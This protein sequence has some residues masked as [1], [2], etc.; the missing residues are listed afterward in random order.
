[1]DFRRPVD[2]LDN[3]GK[4]E[5]QL[6]GDLA[7]Q[8]TD[9]ANSEP[10]L[11][12]CILMSALNIYLYKY[13]KAP[14]IV[15]GSPALKKE[16]DAPNKN[17][18][19]AIISEIAEHCSFKELL[20]YIKG[21]LVESYKKQDY[22]YDD[23]MKEL[24]VDQTANKC[25]LFDVTLALKNIHHEL[26][27]LKNDIDISFNF[28]PGNLTGTISFNE[29]LF[30]KGSIEQL[31]YHYTRVLRVVLQNPG[32]LISDVSLIS[33]EERQHLLFSL[34]DT[35]ADYPSDK[36]I[37]QF[38]EEFAEKTPRAAA[39][40]QGTEKFSFSRLNNQTNQLAHHLQNLGVRTNSVVGVFTDRSPEMIIGLLAVL[41][42]GGAYVPLDS[43]YP[44]DRMAEMVEI[45]EFKL[46]MTK[47]SLYNQLPKN[48]ATKVI[49]L[50]YD[51]EKEKIAAESEE[52]CVTTTTVNDL[53]Y[54]IFTSGSTGVPKGA[55]VY[56]KGWTNLLYWFTKE[57]EINSRDK[58]L[59]VSSF[60]FDLT[61]RA[62]AMSLINGG[63]LHLVNANHYDPDLIKNT[64]AEQRITLMNCAP[65]AIYPILES[66][67]EHT[68]E[69]LASLRILFLGG[70]PISASR[71]KKW[72]E[73]EH[74]HA[75]VA[76]VYG[77]AECTDV[78]IFYVLKDYDR[79][80]KSSV[81]AG[82]PIF[83]TRFY[84][85]DDDLK[86]VPKG[87]V[88]EI[89]IGGDGLGKG[90]INDEA[91]TAEKFIPNPLSQTPGEKLYR[92]GDFGRVL[93]DGNV[94]YLGRGD[95][96][97]K[98]R[99]LRIDLGDI[100]TAIR[101]NDMIKEA[102][103][104]DKALSQQDRR[105]IAY[106]VK[107]QDNDDLTD[108][109]VINRIRKFLNE[110]LP[111]YMVPN[112]FCVLDKLPL[113]PN[114]KIDRNALPIPG[115]SPAGK[116]NGEIGEI[117]EALIKTFAD[118][119]KVETIGVDDNFFQIGGYS[120]LVTQIVSIASQAFNVELTQTDFLTNPTVRGFAQRIRENQAKTN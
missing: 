57:F 27:V 23:L 109:D 61:Q 3:T 70:E 18:A 88:G 102:V 1:L 116:D 74:F 71:L 4:L 75:K 31:S 92:T 51:T 9:L 66:K 21:N 100:E 40:V 29:A 60:S 6:D 82:I 84:I 36:C 56:H 16:D 48:D 63:E 110:K 41:K 17:N 14:C 24:A 103:V 79:Y 112:L 43:S 90:Y 111:S 32:I 8:I 105:L 34:N 58:N 10:F 33:E 81:P 99:G 52:N 49:C 30:Y 87:I 15:V 95:Q 64:I 85:L 118:T 13:K 7:Q 26:P 106:L 2:Y 73:S 78:S 12:Y 19:L 47:L 97:I 59:I 42:A 5:F 104:A 67:E 115:V 119:L 113:T 93:P 39:L 77:I 55:C 11:I 91:L 46:I 86:L 69:K 25:P 101:Q 107:E 89:F 37:H 35:A 68:L 53:S 38:F 94:E 45:G 54:V 96:Q 62:I 50:D 44:R 98:I 20:V 108:E 22:S 120:L 28:E 114:G 72:T 117:E 76:N 80:I 65:S 83:N